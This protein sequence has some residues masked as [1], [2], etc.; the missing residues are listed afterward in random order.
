VGRN[1]LWRVALSAIEL[2]AAL[3]GISWETRTAHIAPGETLVLYTDGLTEAQNAD[4]KFFEETRLI[5]AV[6][7]NLGR[8]AVDIQNAV[9]AAVHKFVGDAQQ[10]DDIALMVVSRLQAPQPTGAGDPREEP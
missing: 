2:L 7:A 9:L 6:Q 5:Q 3:E 1:L 10:F 8:P 4:G